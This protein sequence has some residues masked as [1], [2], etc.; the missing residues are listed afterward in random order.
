MFLNQSGKGKKELWLSARKINLRKI[1]FFLI[2]LFLPTQLGRHFWPR[3]S[4]L[5][6]IRVDYL[7]PTL[8]LTDVFILCLFCISVFCFFKKRNFGNFLRKNRN[9]ILHICLIFVFLAL[10]SV[11]SENVLAGFY[12]EIKFF[13]FVFL[14]FYSVNILK[15]ISFEKILSAFSV[16]IIFESSLSIFQYLNQKSLGGFFY[17]FGERSFTGQTP[18]I[19]NA[20]LGGDLI[21][22]PYGTFPHPNVLAGYLLLFMTLILFNMEGRNKLIKNI[23]LISLILGSLGILLSLGRFPFILWLLTI[24][25]FAFKKNKEKFKKIIISS[26][27]ALSIVVS[28]IFYTP[29]YLRFFETSFFDESFVLRS[30]LLVSAF[31]KILESPIIGHGLN[32]YFTDSKVLGNIFY[33][34]PVHNIFVL[35]FLKVGLIGFLYSLWF[36]IKTIQNFNK[37]TPLFIKLTF[38]Y[39]IIIG[40]FDHYFLT[41]QQGQLMLTFFLS[42]YFAKIKYD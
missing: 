14:G 25:I 42:L 10:T 36:I 11:F 30:E 31:Q 35:V 22:R 1:L 41:L 37:K 13:E 17:L 5:F 26:L 12:G 15:K 40:F 39:I 28:F 19:A 18:G 7:S 23:Y 21:L 27:L 6:G 4:Y 8:Y 3:F 34:Q 29:F 38:F 32:N 20:S 2:L 9:K 24:A 16:G 33:L